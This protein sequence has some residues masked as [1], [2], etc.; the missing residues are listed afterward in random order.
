VNRR[1]FS[2]I[3]PHI[4]HAHMLHMNHLQSSQELPNHRADAMENPLSYQTGI[5]AG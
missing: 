1:G 2:L 4:A 3:I 5:Q